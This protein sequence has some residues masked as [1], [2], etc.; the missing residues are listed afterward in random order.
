MKTPARYQNASLVDIPKQIKEAM[1]KIQIIEGIYLYGAVGTGKTHICWAIK[2][3]LEK[4][5]SYVTLWNVVD[6]IQEIKRDFDR[7][8]SDKKRPELYLENYEYQNLVIL[9]DIGAEKTT[10]FVTET[11]Y[12]IINQRYI[13]QLP[14]IFTSNYSVGELAER[15]GDRSTS[16]I[17]EM[18]KIVEL[19]CGDRRLQK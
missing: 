15:I 9:D 14:T 18:C 10:D 13:H 11:L 6:L 8:P 19:T 7:E 3:H 17:V 12:R 4:N 16:R 2:N 5:K 1:E